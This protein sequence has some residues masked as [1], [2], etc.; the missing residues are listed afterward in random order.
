MKK[1]MCALALMS[2]VG[3]TTTNN[4]Q[5]VQPKPAPEMTQEQ[6]DQAAIQAFEAN[7]V[8]MY[9]HPVAE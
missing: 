2:L 3:C 1:I 8:K 4:D 7:Q 9:S 5:N 6:K